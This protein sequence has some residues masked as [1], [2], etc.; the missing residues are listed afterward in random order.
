MKILLLFFRKFTGFTPDS[1]WT[2]E[3]ELLLNEIVNKETF[4][5]SHYFTAIYGSPYKIMHE[6]NEIWFEQKRTM[7]PPESQSSR[8]SGW[9]LRTAGQAL[10]TT[11]GGVSRIGGLTRFVKGSPLKSLKVSC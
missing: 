7:D 3:A 5:S 1:R 10:Q 4:N 9:F 8:S 11:I 2:E 6:K